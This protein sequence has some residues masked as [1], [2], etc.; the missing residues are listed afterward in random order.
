MCL[1][2]SFDIGDYDIQ[3][4]AIRNGKGTTKDTVKP[5]YYYI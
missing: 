2:L 1:Y 4:T 5:P 3:F